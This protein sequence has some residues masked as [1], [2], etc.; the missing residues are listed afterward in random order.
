MVSEFTESIKNNN[1]KSGSILESVF[2]NGGSITTIGVE[3]FVVDYLGN[4]YFLGPWN[5]VQ[6]AFLSLKDP[7]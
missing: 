2:R 1:E 4:K 7:E 6:G 3:T 5:L